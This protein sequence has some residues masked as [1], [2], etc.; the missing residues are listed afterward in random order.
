MA[1]FADS[2]PSSL[3]NKLEALEKR[4]ERG[5][6]LEDRG[7]EVTGGAL[8]LLWSQFSR[9]WEVDTL[10]ESAAFAAETV[11][12]AQLLE[13]LVGDALELSHCG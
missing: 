1:P 3:Y 11:L 5:P 4:V 13:Q 8:G 12:F 2:H 9:N 10:V 7:R 6:V